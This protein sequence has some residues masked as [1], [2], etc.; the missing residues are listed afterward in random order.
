MTL[1][2]DASVLALRF[3]CQQITVKAATTIAV[4][5]R[6]RLWERRVQQRR[7]HFRGAEPRGYF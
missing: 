5:L 4:A 3:P 7:S 1:E 6:G 2:Q